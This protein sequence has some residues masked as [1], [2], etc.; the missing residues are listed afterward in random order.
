MGSAC[1]SITEQKEAV[2]MGVAVIREL[3]KQDLVCA[4]CSLECPGAQP[5]QLLPPAQHCQNT[6]TLNC[7]LQDAKSCSF[8]TAV[9]EC[10]NSEKSV[11]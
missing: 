5:H 2:G 6:R 11:A 9:S 7:E 8:D 3:E 1:I 4:L 10:T